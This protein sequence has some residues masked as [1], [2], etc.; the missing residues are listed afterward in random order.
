MQSVQCLIPSKN[1]SVIVHC[2]MNVVEIVVLPTLPLYVKTSNELFVE[3][4]GVSQ[5]SIVLILSLSILWLPWLS[6]HQY[7]PLCFFSPFSPS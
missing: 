1:Y 6:Q 7:L 4:V 5:D 2:L 3:V